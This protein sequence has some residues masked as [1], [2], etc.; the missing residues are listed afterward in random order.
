MLYTSLVTEKIYTAF[1]QKSKRKGSGTMLYLIVNKAQYNPHRLIF[2]LSRYST[3][4]FN[5]I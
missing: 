4:L 3:S 5:L 1:S 2:R